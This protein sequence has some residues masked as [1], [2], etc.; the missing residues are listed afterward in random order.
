MARI[1]DELLTNFKKENVVGKFIYVNVAVY[2][3]LALVT[4]VAT[5]FAL[6]I[7]VEHFVRFFELPASL[8]QL[9]YQPWSLV[10]YMFLHGGLTHILWN[11]IALY[12][13]G[14]IFM[15]FYSTRH[16]VGLYLFGG[17]MGG[18]FYIAAYNLLPYFSGEAGGAYLVGASSAVLAVVVAAAIRNPSYRINLFLFGTMR[19]ITVAL[20]TVAASF[21]LTTSSN[22]GGNIAHLGGAFAGWAFAYML[23]KGYDLTKWINA[24]IDFF[25]NFSAGNLKFKFKRKPKM[26]VNTARSAKHSADYEYN[27]RKKAEQDNIDIILDKV[28]KSGYSSLSDDE[29]RRLFDASNRN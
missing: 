5:L 12:Y 14:K 16:F 28:K 3:V 24:V 6:N 19:L 27:A 7:P 25:S 15:Q 18:I 4:V 10:S 9:L 29:K 21:L 22:A 17:I 11:M 1:I 23:N 13:F 20:I 2:L 26:R 8:Q